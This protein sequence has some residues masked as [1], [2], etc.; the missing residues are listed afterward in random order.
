MSDALREER[1]VLWE[2]KE[3]TDDAQL[4]KTDALFRCRFQFFYLVNSHCRHV[5]ISE[6]ECLEKTKRLMIAEIIGGGHE[7]KYLPQTEHC[8]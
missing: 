6:S 4:H 1:E 8:Q 3:S 2:T 7:L 5:R